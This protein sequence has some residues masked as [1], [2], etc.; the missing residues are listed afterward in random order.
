M[1]TASHDKASQLQSNKVLR[2]RLLDFVRKPE[3][4]EDI[5]SYRYEEDGGLWLVDG[6]IKARGDFASIKALAEKENAALQVK[7]EVID[8]SGKL[9]MAGFIDNHIHFPQTQVIGSYGT[10]LLDWLNLYTFPQELRY[11]DQDFADKMAQHFLQMLFDHGTTTAVSFCSV[12]KQSAQALF[13]AADKRSMRLI[14]GKVMMDR[15]APQGLCDTPQSSLDD[16]QELI[17]QWHNKGRLHYA[18]SPRFAITSTPEQLL[19]AQELR[20]NNPDCYLQTHLSENHEEIA[21]SKQLYPEAR[22]Y[23]DIYQHYGLVGERSLFGHCIHLEERERAAMAETG[24]V[25]VFCP[26]SNLFLGSGLFDL[27]GL[28]SQGLRTAIATDVG[29]GTNFSMLRSLDEGY[30]ILQL[31]S[32]KLNPLHA[33]YW[34]TLG[35]A[36]ALGLERHI[37]TLSQDSDADLVVLDSS[38]TAAMEMRMQCVET[39]EQE[40]FMLQTMADDR[41]IIQ[42]YCAGVA[43]KK[44]L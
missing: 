39:L 27:Q 5:T 28:E 34:I 14:A 16:S 2:G 13:Q 10:Q 36:C 6:K 26:T 7:T 20:K 18:I 21:L 38:A 42:T 12:H 37:G 29:G 17:A 25:A 43:Q 22:D 8:H 31:R 19:M 23:F 3:S 35:N 24:S 1:N 9:I 15:N 32:Q 4:L 30:K 41:A 33:F 40:L 11:A 44:P